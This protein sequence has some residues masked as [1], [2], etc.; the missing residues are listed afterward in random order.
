MAKATDSATQSPPVVEND[1]EQITDAEP[2]E[3]TIEELKQAVLALTEKDDKSQKELKRL[4]GVLRSQGVTKQDLAD[5]R[6]EV[7]STQDLLAEAMDTINQGGVGE[8]NEKPKP[9]YSEKLKTM[10]QSSQSQEATDPDAPLFFGYAISQGLTL[11]SPEVKEAMSDGRT[12]KEAFEYLK[13]TIAGRSEAARKAEITATVQAALKNHG[14]TQGG[15]GAPTTGG[16]KFTLDKIKNMS[17]EEIIANQ[18]AI[19]QAMIAGEL[20]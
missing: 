14:L 11:E 2:K 17:D 7:T 12:G 3:P 4:Q 15:A 10:R 20:K 9:S 13:A 1:A 5:L 19:N 8:F 16:G 6:Q 18:E